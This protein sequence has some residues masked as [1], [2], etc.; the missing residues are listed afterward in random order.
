MAG[1]RAVVNL[2][3][4]VPGMCP[5]PPPRANAV[6]GDGHDIYLK[7]R[8][9]QFPEP[10]STSTQNSTRNGYRDDTLTEN[11]KGGSHMFM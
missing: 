6:K 4:N 2:F 1:G 7:K 8:A 9:A 5:V 11:R 3:I 10:L